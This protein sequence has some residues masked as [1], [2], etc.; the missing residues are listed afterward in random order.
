MIL[1]NED[2]DRLQIHI[3][4]LDENFGLS[5]KT[6]RDVE[7]AMQ[8]ARIKLID[9]LP[10]NMK[11]FCGCIDRCSSKRKDYFCSTDRNCAHQIKR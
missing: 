11:F 3:N 8:K 2:L 4:E 10:E 5:F 1:T 6:C 9:E 7:F